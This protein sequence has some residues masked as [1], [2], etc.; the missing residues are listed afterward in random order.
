MKGKL[1]NKPLLEINELKIHYSLPW[2]ELKKS[3]PVKEGK[4]WFKYPY[5]PHPHSVVM[6]IKEPARYLEKTIQM[7]VYEKDLKA[8]I[9]AVDGVSLSIYRNKCISIIGETGCGKT[10][11]LLSLFRILPSN[12]ILHDGEIHYYHPDGTSVNFFSLDDKQLRQ[13]F[14]KHVSLILQNPGSSFNPAF[15]IGFQIGEVLEKLSWRQEQIKERVIEYLG[16]VALSPLVR[17]KW[18]KQLS[19]GEAQ[20]ACIASALIADP[21]I[22]FGDEPL[23]SLDTIIKAQVIQLLIN[24]KLKFNITYVFT[25][26]DISVA[27]QLGD[28]IAVM[29]GGEMVEVQPTRKF[30]AEP[31]HPYGK[32]LLQATPWYSTHHE[33]PLAEIKGE[34]PSAVNWPTG[35]KFHPRCP[36]CTRICTI[37]KP[38]RVKVGEGFVECFLYT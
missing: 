32:G 34:I 36:S 29:Y 13:Y 12:V 1:A 4:Y 19:G 5:T 38:P 37:K 31:L 25:T 14:G 2:N 8:L 9:K 23:K 16:K 15:Q 20:R 27:G 21:M 24:L 6:K 28:A 26:H 35:C 22:L 30:L 7:E 17:K 10:S 33:L 11:L 18:S 3:T